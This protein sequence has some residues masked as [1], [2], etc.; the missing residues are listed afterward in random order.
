[1]LDNKI[2]MSIG[3]LHVLELAFQIKYLLQAFL[4][5]LLCNKVF[6]Y[7]QPKSFRNVAHHL[8]KVFQI[9]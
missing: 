7:S 6:N 4:H 2:V 9:K 1:M 5:H 8:G 3:N